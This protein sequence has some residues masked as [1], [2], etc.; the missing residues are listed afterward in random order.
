LSATNCQGVSAPRKREKERADTEAIK[1]FADNLRE[2]LLAPPLGKK[3]VLAIDPGIRTGCNVVCLD[4]QG[5]LL[6]TDTIY[7]F[8]SEKS[9]STAFVKVFNDN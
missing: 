2:L 3:N 7:L 5:N 9:R 6:R 8:G 4:R 1:V